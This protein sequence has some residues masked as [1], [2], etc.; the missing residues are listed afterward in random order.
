MP[1]VSTKVQILP[2]ELDLLVDRVARRAGDLV[3]DDALLADGLVEQARLADVRAA[4]DRN[5]ART[6]DLVLGDRRHLRQNR[7]DVVEQVG[8]AAT[9]QGG[10]GPRLPEAQ[11]PQLGGLRVA[12][13]VVRLVGDEDDR[14]LRRTQHLD[15]VLV[16]RRGAD[17]DVDD[18]QH[19]VG[20]I[21]RDLGLRRDRR[22]DPL[23]VG[24]PATGVD[25]REP[26]AQPLGLVGDAVAGDAGGVLDDGLAPAQDAVHERGLAHVG[27]ADDR[28]HGQRG[29]VRDAVR[30]SAAA[31]SRPRSSS[32]SS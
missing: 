15:D 18:E 26:A 12:D 23:R 27:A 25:D 6:A 5:P 29:Q 28:E 2:A 4:D 19:G 7:H 24:L 31:S 9:V 13:G 21:D 10:D 30:P 8:D 17:V 14:A 22:V 1:A 3:D 16:G 11:A 32:S 20:E